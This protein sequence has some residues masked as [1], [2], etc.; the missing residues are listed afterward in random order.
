MLS[1]VAREH[2]NTAAKS[3]ASAPSACK[4]RSIAALS[5]VI[6]TRR[7]RAFGHRPRPSR[8]LGALSPTK[9]ITDLPANPPVKRP[10]RSLLPRRPPPHLAFRLYPEAPRTLR[11]LLLHRV[12]HGLAGSSSPSGAFSAR[13]FCA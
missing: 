3:S 2:P 6:G 5:R 8:C 7:L 13:L 4:S 12:R 9:L 10:R 11:L 1:T